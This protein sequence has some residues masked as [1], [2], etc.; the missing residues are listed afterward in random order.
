M[1]VSG[2]GQA[3]VLN[4]DEL[5]LLFSE[6]FNST[7]DRA[8]FGICL[9][10]ACRISEALQLKIS[11]VG[12]SSIV[13]RKL[14]TKGKLKSRE[15]KIVPALR[16]LLDDYNPEHGVFYFPGQRLRREFLSRNHA[17]SLLRNACLKLGFEGVS[18][19]SFRRTALTRMSSAGIPLKVIQKI[20]GH[21][22]LGTLSLYLEVNE[23]ELYRA[24]EMIQY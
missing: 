4:P 14:N 21:G 18:T 11:D 13:F 20:S 23:E 2:N 7:R 5:K 16:C 6:G 8:L 1:K 17:D 10:T 15:V 22:D 24:V 3:S 19:H 9:Y 12:R